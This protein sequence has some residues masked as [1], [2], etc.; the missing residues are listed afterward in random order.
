MLQLEPHRHSEQLWQCFLAGCCTPHVNVGR[1]I[2]YRVHMQKNSVHLLV[3]PEIDHDHGH[4]RQKNQTRLNPVLQP[5][6][7]FVLNAHAHGETKSRLFS[8]DYVLV[9]RFPN[10]DKKEQ[11][12]RG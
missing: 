3:H 6:V 9:L 10:A 2:G 11:C 12:R 8:Y 5:N 4:P 7:P 1:N